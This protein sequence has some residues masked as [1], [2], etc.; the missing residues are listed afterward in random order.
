[1]DFSYFKIHLEDPENR[2][3]A[4][5]KNDEPVEL[6]DIFPTLVDLVKLPK[7]EKCPRNLVESRKT[8]VCTE[9]KSILDKKSNGN[10]FAMTQYPRPSKEPQ[11]TSGFFI[12]NINLAFSNVFLSVAY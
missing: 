11:Q 5:T 2:L 3:R 8:K 9:G 7:L 12:I 10:Y 1:M 4:G 6:L